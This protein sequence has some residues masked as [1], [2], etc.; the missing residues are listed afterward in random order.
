MDCV[1]TYVN[2]NSLTEDAEYLAGIAK[3]FLSERGCDIDTVLEW[4]WEVQVNAH[5]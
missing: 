1:Q 3:Q 2:G 5:S 4:A